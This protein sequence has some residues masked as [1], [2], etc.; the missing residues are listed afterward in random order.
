M[1]R[2]IGPRWPLLGLAFLLLQP[3]CVTALEDEPFT[4]SVVIFN[5]VCAKCH[6]GECSGRLS[7]ENTHEPAVNH[8]LRHYRAAGEKRW[9]QGELFVILA[10]MKD[11]CAYYPMQAPI[12]PN[13]VW[14][15]DRL[16][17]MRIMPE[18]S[19]FVPLGPLPP[20]DY[21]L[22]LAFERDVKATIQ[23]VSGQF[24]M[25][26]E[27]YLASRDS[28]LDIPFAIE[29]QGNYYFRMYPRE[30]ARITGLSITTAGNGV[31]HP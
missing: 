10:H 12:P 3:D 14:G 23:L 25:V 28:H 8:I 21:R 7:F 5:T 20:G 13:R 26:V 27:E 30:A 16:D 4:E 22:G 6:E 31:D 11:K 9:L 17:R 24:E 18:G 1:K 29:A 15:G 2:A 19:Y